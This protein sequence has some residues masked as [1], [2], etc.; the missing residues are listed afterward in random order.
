M[1]D[2]IVAK[3]YRLHGLKLSYFTGKLEAYLQA[4][5]VAFDFVEMDTADFKACARATGIAQMPQLE[6]PDGT[7]LTD[8]TKIIAHFEAT[9]EGPALSPK[10]PL[11]RFLS[12]V[13][14]DYCDEWLWRPALYYRWAFTQDATLMSDTLARTMLRDVPLPLWL[15]KAYILHRQRRVYLR[16]DAVTAATAPAI[17]RLYRETLA[18]LETIFAK[19]AYLFGA[20]PCEADFGLFG[21]MFRH[22]SSDPT[23]AAMLREEAPHVGLWTARL[24]ATRPEHIAAAPEIGEA[25]EDLAPL[26]QRAGGA[27]LPY[28]AANAEAVRNGAPE[29][30]YIQDGILWRTKTSPYRAGCLAALS[31]TFRALSSEEQSQAAARLG[32]D[33]AVFSESNAME[34][35]SK[36][37]GP[38]PGGPVVDR[39]GRRLISGV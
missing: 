25:P 39:A 34:A 27:Y 36:A 14:E 17:E 5:G 38:R 11:T 21:P 23:P 2:R 19:R 22:F 1:T 15:R 37:F 28:L 33:P 32:I 16:E 20:R 7:W 8:T 3:P 35:A 29:T 30:H 13:L 12:L 31:V 10:S 26:L 4:K 9:H 18:E 24:W 6:G